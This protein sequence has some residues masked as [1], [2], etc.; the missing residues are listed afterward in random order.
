MQS[1]CVSLWIFFWP[2]IC[3]LIPWTGCCTD[4]MSLTHQ[5][6][7]PQSWTFYMLVV[8]TLLLHQF[9]ARLLQPQF[10]QKSHWGSQKVSSSR[11]FVFYETLDSPQ[12]TFSFLAINNYPSSHVPY[13][14]CH[15]H[16][17]LLLSVIFYNPWWRLIP[18]LQ[19]FWSVT[20]LNKDVQLHKYKNLVMALHEHI[21]CH[22]TSCYF[23][24]DLLIGIFAQLA[25]CILFGA[26]ALS[27]Q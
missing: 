7:N 26:P 16:L 2:W 14:S 15:N 24:L 22:F 3:C 12:I 8:S 20:K 9:V 23:V 21:S 11:I 18:W 17:G 6:I 27:S 13:S 25:S 1:C 5:I 10:I 19:D 4:P